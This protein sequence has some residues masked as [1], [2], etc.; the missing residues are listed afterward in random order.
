MVAA[1]ARDG[2]VRLF[3]QPVLLV[4]VG[5]GFG[6]V[7]AVTPDTPPPPLQRVL[8]AQ[9]LEF[10]FDLAMMIH[11]LADLYVLGGSFPLEARV[12]VLPVPLQAPHEAADFGQAGHPGCSLRAG[13]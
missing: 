7:S 6:N 3:S 12:S 2:G 1:L 10:R 13:H 8:V 4:Q 11:I 9:G 5:A